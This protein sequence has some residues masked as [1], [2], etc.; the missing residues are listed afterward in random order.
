[1]RRW[2]CRRAAG[3]LAPDF[4]SRLPPER[5]VRV[6]KERATGLAP[7]RVVGLDAEGCSAT[8]R[9]RAADG[10]LWVAPA[11]SVWAE[12]EPRP[13]SKPDVA[14]QGT[15]V[16]EDGLVTPVHSELRFNQS[17]ATS[18][19]SA[20]GSKVRTLLRIQASGAATI[21]RSSDRINVA[22]ASVPSNTTWLIVRPPPSATSCRRKGE[23][24]AAATAGR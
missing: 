20:S 24:S 23:T 12:S 1:M 3:V 8:A 13:S 9:F 10:D 17:T 22:A 7:I 21:T 18:R 4:A 6:M 14:L 11:V 5:F 15:L 16:T 2:R 19:P